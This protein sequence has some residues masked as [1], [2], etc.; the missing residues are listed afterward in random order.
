MHTFLC[1]RREEAK[2]LGAVRAGT[3]STKQM[4]GSFFPGIETARA[5]AIDVKKYLRKD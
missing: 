5:G 1:I 4:R 2:V 3:T